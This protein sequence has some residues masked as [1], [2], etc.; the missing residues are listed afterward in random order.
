MTWI[1]A[2]QGGFKEVKK[3]KTKAKLKKEIVSS[4]DAV[5]HTPI[6]I[7]RLNSKLGV[8]KEGRKL[9]QAALGELIR[10]GKVKLVSSKRVMLARPSV[11]LIGKFLL[12]PNGNGFVS[13]RGL[14][15][16]V[17]VPRS[18]AKGAFHNDIVEIELT[19]E[20][21][22]RLAGRVIRVV[23]RGIRFVLGRAEIRRGRRILSVEDKKLSARFEILRSEAGEVCDGELALGL[24]ADRSG[25]RRGVIVRERF[26]RQDTV[27]TLTLSTVCLYGFDKEFPEEALN[28]AGRLPRKV[29]KGKGR[30]DLTSYPFVTI[31]GENAR[32][33][34]DAVCVLK[35]GKDYRLLVSIADV[36]AY[37]PWGTALDLEARRRGTSVYFP[38]RVVPMF[39]E[40]LSNDL[41]SL[42][43]G[44]NRLTLT[45]DVLLDMK[46]DVKRMKV[47]PSVIRSRKRLT[48]RKVQDFLDGRGEIPSGLGEMINHM[49]DLARVLN[50]RR[51]SEGSLD[52]DLPES[53]VKISLSGKLENV[54]TG[55]RL[56]AHRIIEEFMLL[57]N[58]CV[59]EYLDER[60]FPL[61]YR[62]H[63]QPDPVKLKDFIKFASLFDEG[64][65]SIRSFDRKSLQWVLDRVRGK[66]YE[67]IVNLVMLRSFKLARYSPINVGHFGLAFPKYTHFTSPIRRYPDLVVHRILKHALGAVDAEDRVEEI[68][69]SLDSLGDALSERERNAEQAER[70]VVDKL[71][72]LFMK[73]REGEEFEG[74][75]SSIQPFGLFVALEKFPVEGLIP[76]WSLPG[77]SYVAD[78]DGFFLR[79]VYTGDV[80]SLGDR[81]RVRVAECDPPKGRVDFLLVEKGGQRK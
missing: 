9:V 75:V 32:D 76:I 34:D 19:R 77:D 16:D 27:N 80:I 41:C 40:R 24:I 44:V 73:D 22:G 21:R 6:T 50:E 39:P 37:V 47:Y 35:E 59:A 36:S 33:F 12:T 11:K 64:V 62:I 49:A 61:L 65:R 63:E 66:S 13:V 18:A 81:V 42:R 48:Y 74:T 3:G 5:G 31:D 45:V 23:E 43:E 38:D 51:L 68:F 28:E 4:L 71:K 69:D 25:P 15:G 1:T 46:G 7:R 26:G 78:G 10:E 14:G 57:A 54:F 79:G 58:V 55:E 20:R 67:K 2:N 60:G 30:E 72:A 8:G 56:F 29:K 17:F 52:F 53:E 70:D